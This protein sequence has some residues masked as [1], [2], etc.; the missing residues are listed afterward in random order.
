MRLRF[1]KSVSL[2]KSAR[3]LCALESRWAALTS[4]L[5][6]LVTARLSLPE[7]AITGK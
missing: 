3:Q 5:H 6:R 1:Q 4:L 2:P 7:S